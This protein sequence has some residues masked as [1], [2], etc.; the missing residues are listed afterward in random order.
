MVVKHCRAGYAEA[1]TALLAAIERR[2][3][4]VFARIDHGAAA[5]GITARSG[6]RAHTP[7]RASA[8]AQPFGGSVRA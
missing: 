3:L 4:T 1:L 6:E 8:G 7:R 2:R 5:N